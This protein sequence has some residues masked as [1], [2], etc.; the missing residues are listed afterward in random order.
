MSKKAMQL[1]LEALTTADDCLS[2]LDTYYARIVTNCCD[3]A[4]DTL[5]GALAEDALQHHTAAYQEMEQP[6]PTCERDKL[7]NRLRLG[8]SI[9]RDRRINEDFAAIAD[10]AADMLEADA[11]KTPYGWMVN[12]SHQVFFG[13]HAE[14][15]AKRE[16]VRIG[17]TCK[18]F[19][20]YKG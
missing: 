3:A 5:R 4:I 6:R 8:A 12:G 11:N 20:I 17:G 15:D 1:A 16:A 2:H 19:P 9:S 13:E 14:M 18:A 7:I 10:D